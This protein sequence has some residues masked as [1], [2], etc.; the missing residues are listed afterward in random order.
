METTITGP[1]AQSP[2][3]QY[4]ESVQKKSLIL[5]KACQSRQ[6]IDLTT[7]EPPPSTQPQIVPPATSTSEDDF[8]PIDDLLDEEEELPDINDL[9]QTGS[10]RTQGTQKSTQKA[11]GVLA[12]QNNNDKV[13]KK[14]GRP[15]GSKNTQ[16]ESANPWDLMTGSFQ[17]NMQ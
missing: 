4:I 16:K 8:V 15:R 2:R 7:N 3:I 12:P 6:A 11:P 13:K 5:S 1:L 14:P 9:L 10:Q 17:V